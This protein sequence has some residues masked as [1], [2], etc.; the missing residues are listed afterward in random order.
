MYV[1]IY[2]L[3]DMCMYI[4][5]MLDHLLASMSVVSIPPPPGM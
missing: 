4:Y 1:Y 2:L 5:Y 3:I